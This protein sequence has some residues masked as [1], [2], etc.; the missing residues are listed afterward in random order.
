MG[1]VRQMGQYGTLQDRLGELFTYSMGVQA[2]SSTVV[3]PPYRPSYKITA[4]ELHPNAPL[5]GG[6]FDSRSISTSFMD[7]N[8]PLGGVF[9]YHPVLKRLVT[10]GTP[11]RG[12]Y[13]LAPKWIEEC[14]A[15]LMTQCEGYGPEAWNKFKPGRPDV[16]IAQFIAELKD[17]KGM[18]LDFRKYVD[19]VR[20]MRRIGKNY[21]AIQFGWRPFLHDLWDWYQSIRKIDQRIAKLRKLN[22]QWHRRGGTLFRDED[23]TSKTGTDNIITPGNWLTAKGWTVDTTTSTR[24]WFK[25]SFRYYIPGLDDPKWGRLRAHQEIWDLY[26]TPELLWELFPW[27]WLADWFSNVGPIIS[28]LSSQLLDNV[29]ARY[30]YVMLQTTKD[31]IWRCDAINRYTSEYNK[32]KTNPVHCE[33]HFKLEQ[34]TR[35]EASPF[36]FNLTWEGLSPY[37]MSILTALGISRRW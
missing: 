13:R 21:L 33:A 34:K 8:C 23:T 3:S 35:A 5:S 19:F 36:G 25:G 28:N 32:P 26:I 11:Y 30:A 16:G 31:V 15:S 29:A 9:Y 10:S 18:V 7:Q 24:C 27:S 14:P 37:Q 17:I 20:N 12:I 22:G 4:D 6:P 1:R 2:T